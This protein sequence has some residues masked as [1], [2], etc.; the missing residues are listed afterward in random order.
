MQQKKSVCRFVLQYHALLILR[1]KFESHVSKLRWGGGLETTSSRL[2]GTNSWLNQTRLCLD[3]VHPGVG[4][5]WLAYQTIPK[6]VPNIRGIVRE[7]IERLGPNIPVWLERVLLDKL[8]LLLAGILYRTQPWNRMWWVK[9][10]NRF[11]FLGV[12]SYPVHVTSPRVQRTTYPPKGFRANHQLIPR[13][14]PYFLFSH[15][16]RTS[17]NQ[18]FHILSLSRVSFAISV[19][20]DV[21]HP[22]YLF[23]SAPFYFGILVMCVILRF[24]SVVE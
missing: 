1:P 8:P 16:R 20:S 24:I 21:A 18:R 19:I 13:G 7:G 9:Q 10:S 12:R 6:C 17:T 15:Q 2:G 4:G 14:D 3:G 22:P 23:V 11:P 5:S